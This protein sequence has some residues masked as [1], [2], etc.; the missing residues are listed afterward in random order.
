MAKDTHLDVLSRDG[1]VAAQIAKARCQCFEQIPQPG[2]HNE[3]FSFGTNFKRYSQI[4][5]L[6]DRL[7]KLQSLQNEVFVSVCGM[8]EMERP[9]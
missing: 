5:H 6:E 3:P 1:S 2:T 9:G 4:C 8:S 7:L